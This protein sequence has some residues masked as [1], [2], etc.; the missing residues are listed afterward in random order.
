M[1]RDA[2]FSEIGRCLMNYE[3]GD[4]LLLS[5]LSD[6][7]VALKDHFLESETG[8]YLVDW[9]QRCI[10][11]E[12]KQASDTHIVECISKRIDLL[13][14]LSAA[15]TPDEIQQI[16]KRIY[17]SSCPRG[18]TI[19][20]TIVEDEI[21]RDDESLAIFL[22]EADDRLNEAQR[23]ILLLEEDGNTDEHL[24]TLFR[25]F[26]T[27]KGECGFLKIATLG[28]ITHNIESLLD[29]LRKGDTEFHP[30]H[31]DI[32]LEGIDLSATILDQLKKG[33]TVL[34]NEISIDSYYEKLKKATANE[35][36]SLGEVLV[37]E[38]VLK[39][40]DV[41]RILQLQKESAYSKRF[42]EIA[43]TN[44]YLTKE[45]LQKTLGKQKEPEKTA[46]TK[47][48]ER[49]DPVIKVKS[50]KVTFLVDMIGELLIAMG[51][52]TDNTPAVLQM[53]KI[54]RSIQF[55]AMELKTDT[56]Q[57][58]FGTIKRAVRD[59]AKQTGKNVQL[60]TRGD[61]LEI[62]RDLIEKLEEPL[63]H[64]VRNSM[65]HGLE[66]EKT[67]TESLK[68]GQGTITLTAERRGNSIIIALRD[69]GRGLDRNQI[70]SKAIEKG[71]VRED[72]AEGLTDAQI[73][74]LIFK[75]GFSTQENV[76]LISG[77]G[78]G[79]D[80]VR[81]VVQ[82]N[83]GRIETETMPGQYTEFRL[84]FPLSTAI[85]DGMITR[86]GENL[87]VI[88][89]SSIIET[90][91]IEQG[92][93]NSVS[94]KV[95]VINLRGQVMPVVY[96][97]DALGLPQKEDRDWYMG[98]VVE[99]TDQSR[100]LILLDEVIAKREVVIKSLGTKFSTMRGV[101]SGTVLSGGKIGLVI[102]IDQLIDLS[103]IEGST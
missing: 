77:R 43:V 82:D 87:I 50:S 73:Y 48:S 97:H 37:D 9:I 19:G 60:V 65:D 34:F 4:F 17:A 41:T 36:K 72:T 93:L 70:L 89:V 66:E 46:R 1:D 31:V 10:H 100:F 33:K 22:A 90:L 76:S 92:M 16:E 47:G 20:E 56:V 23:I 44:N 30:L 28:E 67:R 38:G 81:S 35:K 25:V 40:S 26:H 79:M 74:T 98:I 42:G 88:P 95:E 86:T 11:S 62:D 49:S 78:V 59:L 75:P 2:L 102:D 7:I 85:I 80:I 32:L 99:R 57:S 64:L 51:Q 12:M 13:Q 101:T 61:S 21:P 52:V 83:R 103:L 14:M 91:K 96:M 53:R 58:L 27:I 5:D 39:E 3:T 68:P 94:G 45:E 6:L 55:A 71:L 15:S 69:D 8:S 18:K 63:M 29:S 54:T 84:I 24:Q